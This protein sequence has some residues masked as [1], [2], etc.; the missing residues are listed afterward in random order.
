MIQI[1]SGASK[2]VAVVMPEKERDA[3]VVIEE[4]HF[5]SIVAHLCALSAVRSSIMVN[6]AKLLKMTN[7]K[8][9]SKHIM[10]RT[11]QSVV[12]VPRKLKVAIK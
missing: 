5:V 8:T 1:Q 4:R 7:C 9:T 3:F 10:S 2:R 6:V 12:M 11:V